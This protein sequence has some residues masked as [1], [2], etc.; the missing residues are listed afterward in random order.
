MDDRGCRKFVVDHIH[1][2]EKVLRK[3]EDVHL[4]LSK[5]K[6]AFGQEQILVVVILGCFE[7]NISLLLFCVLRVSPLLCESVSLCGRCVEAT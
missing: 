5:E 7:Y 1:D 3:L 6:S 2:C 4:T